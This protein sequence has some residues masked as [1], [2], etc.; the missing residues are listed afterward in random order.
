MH[1]DGRLT[2]HHDF[3]WRL[4]RHG[5]DTFESF[6]DERVGELIRDVGVRDNVRL[7][8]ESDD[9]RFIFYLKRHRPLG[10]SEKIGAWLRCRRARTAARTEWEN[11]S[12]LASLGIP[13]MHPVAL[14]EDPVS[15]R[16]FVMTAEIDSAVQGDDFAREH[17]A[18]TDRP[19]A[20]YRRRFAYGLGRLVR[21]LHL[22]GLTHRDLYLCHIFVRRFEQDFRLYLIDL[23]RVSRHVFKR[24]WRVKDVAQL[25][26]SCPTGTFTRTDRVTFLHAYFDVKR[27]GARQKRFVRSV[28][29]KVGRMRR[30]LAPREDA[31]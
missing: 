30:R 14:G 9:G 7:T 24:R 21:R 23:Q 3:I 2:V 19:T 31:R 15:G 26:Y 25:E 18:S 20:H 4:H 11:I 28:L 16:S 22:A 27:L 17:L 1:D 5:L 12:R 10:L 29:R 13:T 8:L 6:D